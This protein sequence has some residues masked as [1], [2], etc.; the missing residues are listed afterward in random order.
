MAQ[1]KREI[2]TEFDLTFHVKMRVFPDTQETE[3]R[4]FAEY[5]EREI[6]RR[7]MGS[8]ETFRLKEI[9]HADKQ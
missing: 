7:S 8:L 1:G 5:I 6:C 4:I 3:R 2:D 9:R